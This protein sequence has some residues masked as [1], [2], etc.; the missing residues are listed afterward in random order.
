MT[1][2]SRRKN[3]KLQD[4]DG[5]TRSGEWKSV[6]L[7]KLPKE[8]REYLIKVIKEQE[9]AYEPTTAVGGPKR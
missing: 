6:A 3:T 7:P 1:Q 2:G 5:S 9:D 8:Q 4:R